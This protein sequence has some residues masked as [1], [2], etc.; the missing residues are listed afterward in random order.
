MRMKKITFTSF[1]ANPHLIPVLEGFGFNSLEDHLYF[2]P[3]LPSFT[4]KVQVITEK[5]LISQE[6]TGESLRI[7]SDHKDLSCN[8]VVLDSPRGNCYM[9]FNRA[10]KKNL[11]VAFLDYVSNVDIF[12]S[13]IQSSSSRIC[14]RLG[15]AA[16]MIGAH[17]L[18]GNSLPG[19]LKISRKF[20]LWF[21]SE[22]LTAFDMDTLYSEY[23]VLGLQPT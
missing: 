22:D 6:L 10:Q 23:Q 13:Y 1:T 8:H 7:F 2:L 11:P 21:R 9:V 19:S 14:S 3:P 15:V 16:L 5:E 4:H 17:T 18:K 12:L 20:K